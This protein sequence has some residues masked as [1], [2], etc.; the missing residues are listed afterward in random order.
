MIES[1]RL[2]WVNWVE[3]NQ[4]SVRLTKL[5]G[6]VGWEDMSMDTLMIVRRWIRFGPE[7]AGVHEQL[8]EGKQ[9]QWVPNKAV[10][11]VFGKLQRQGARGR[12][13]SGLTNDYEG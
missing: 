8:G 13:W 12:S 4:N 5:V 2:K 1:T 6:W 3:L 9:A 11:P 7:M 10:I